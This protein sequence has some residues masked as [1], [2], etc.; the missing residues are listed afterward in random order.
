MPGYSMMIPARHT[1]RVQNKLRASKGR[2]MRG[3]G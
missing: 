2:S 3:T 1:I